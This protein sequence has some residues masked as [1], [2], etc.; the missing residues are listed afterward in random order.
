MNEKLYAVLKDEMMDACRASLERHN[1]EDFYGISLYTCGEYLYLHDAF[2]T[3]EGL[4]KAARKY[5][6]DE[7]Y[8]RKWKNLDGAMQRLK[9]SSCDSPYHLEVGEIFDRTADILDEIWESMDEQSSGHIK[10]N[11]QQIHNTCL[12]VLID[13]RRSGLFDEDRV[14]F[15]LLK[16]DQSDE[17]RWANAKAVNSEKSLES[18]RKDMEMDER[19]V[20]EEFERLGERF[21]GYF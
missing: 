2:C 16:G 21:E 17:E 3:V 1:G 11:C 13:V 19:L 10:F 14:L 8:Q 4:E 6:K 18:Y 9:W 20:R 15:N 5:L 7:Y 12:T